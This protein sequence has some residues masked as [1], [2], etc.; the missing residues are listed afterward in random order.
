MRPFLRW[1]WVLWGIGLWGGC[2]RGPQGRVS[3]SPEERQL[4]FYQAKLRALDHEI[5]RMDS[6]LQSGI[7]EDNRLR[8]Q[9]IRTRLLVEKEAWTRLRPSRVELPR[10]TLVLTIHLGPQGLQVFSVLPEAPPNPRA[11]RWVAVALVGN[12]WKALAPGKRYR[13]VV[14]PVLP[15]TFVQ[16]TTAY[17]CIV[18][19]EEVKQK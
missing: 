13:V 16:R 15:Q 14:L 2:G 12:Q 5:Q 18:A 3:A 11:P 6:L 10:D 4:L 1:V 17:A 9:R 8:L 19:Y 7:H